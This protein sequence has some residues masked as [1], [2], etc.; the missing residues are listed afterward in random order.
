MSPH[1]DTLSRFLANQSLLF[2][3]Y[4]VCLTEKQQILILWS[5]VWQ[6]RPWLWS[7]ALKASMLTIKLLMPFQLYTENSEMTSYWATNKCLTNKEKH[8]LTQWRVQLTKY[9]L[10]ICNKKEIQASYR[11][12]E[13]QEFATIQQSFF[14]YVGL[15]FICNW[16]CSTN[17]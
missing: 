3:L 6:Y 4:A 9:P 8:I 7:T 16:K 12:T 11:Q 13:K 14:F 1:S 5:L 17:S 10:L 15:A 2:L